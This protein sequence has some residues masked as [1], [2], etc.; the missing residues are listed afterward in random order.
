MLDK[1]GY[2]HTPRICNTCSFSAATVVT[3]TLLI[4]TLHIHFLSRYFYLAEYLQVMLGEYFWDC[5]C[6]IKI[7]SF[8]HINHSATGL[9]FPVVWRFWQCC[10][11]QTKVTNIKKGRITIVRPILSPF[12][13][14]LDSMC[15]TGNDY[16]CVQV[17]LWICEWTDG[18]KTFP[19]VR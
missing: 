11:Y 18:L 10:E 15:C 13:C 6:C 16:V 14:H 1:E 5:N 2:K 12:V 4:V 7:F 8:Q 19:R 17:I 9:C 3:R